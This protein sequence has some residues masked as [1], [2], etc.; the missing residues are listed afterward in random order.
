[1][2]DT[3]EKGHKSEAF[4]RVAVDNTAA[5]VYTRKDVLD[6]RRSAL[7]DAI[8]ERRAEA[9]S[10]GQYLSPHIQALCALHKV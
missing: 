10:G 4:L 2:S 6:A 3:F 9:R 7:I 1:M 5:P 8:T